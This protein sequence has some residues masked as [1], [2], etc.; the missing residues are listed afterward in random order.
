MFSQARA[1][2]QAVQNSNTQAARTVSITALHMARMASGGVIRG[3]LWRAAE[4]GHVSWCSATG[5]I[6]MVACCCCSSSIVVVVVSTSQSSA[7]N[8]LCV[9]GSERIVDWGQ[10]VRIASPKKDVRDA[11]SSGV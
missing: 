1:H 7:R 6:A 8:P 2:H 11:W 9:S 3:W 5:G 4:R 10:Y